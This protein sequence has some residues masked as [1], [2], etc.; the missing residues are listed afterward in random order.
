MPSHVQKPEADKIRFSGEEAITETVEAQLKHRY[1]RG[2]YVHDVTETPSG[3]LILNVGNVIPRDLS[4]SREH[5]NVIKFVPIDR[6]YQMQA[7]GTNDG[8]V[9]EL[10][11][12][13]L[14]I[15]GFN[16]RRQEIVDQVDL[17]MARTIYEDI[18]HFGEVS[19]QLAPIRQI[20]HWVRTRSP[21]HVQTINNNQRSDQTHEYIHVLEKLDYL[22]IDTEGMVHAGETLDSI[23]LNDV[24]SSN[25]NEIILGDVVQRGYDILRD[26][27]DLRILRHYPMISG[28]YYYDAVQRD[29]PGLWL[30]LDAIVTGIYDQF[31]KSYKPLYI[32]EKLAQLSRVGALRKDGDFVQAEPTI[33]REVKQSLQG[34]A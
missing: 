4:D 11:E 21:I 2:I 29:D 9:L 3:N 7:Q 19:N 24:E 32:E 26:E 23:E 14:L 34:F 15:D 31:G 13:E 18:A 17:T 30:D 12:R 10:P 5:D 33:F 20:L 1:G 25:F 27:L 16:Q 6:I 22:T 28:A 8:Y